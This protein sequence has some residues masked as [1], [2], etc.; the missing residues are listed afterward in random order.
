MV[1]VH[2][3]VDDTH[4]FDAL[5]MNYSALAQY[6][7]ACLARRLSTLTVGPAS[8]AMCGD[9]RDSLTTRLNSSEFSTTLEAAYHS[10]GAADD[11]YVVFTQ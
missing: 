5:C 7:F 9:R 1:C 2:I 4:E 6:T 3:L 10:A 8:F 11:L